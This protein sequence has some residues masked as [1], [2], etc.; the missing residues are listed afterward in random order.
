MGVLILNTWRSDSMPQP[1]TKAQVLKRLQTE[2]SRLEQN[3]ARLTQEE[4]LQPGVV[5]EW[6]V[7]DVLAHLGDWIARMSVWVEAARR[8]ETVYCPDPDF[9]WKQIDRLNQH[10]YEA[11]RDQPLNEVLAYFRATF[12]QFISMVEA[13]PE[14]EMFERGRFAFVGNRP[15]YDWIGLYAAHD[16][17][18]KR[19]IRVWLKTRAVH[20]G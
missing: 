3:L 1:K 10:I 15:L 12:N 4:M 17:W 8:G 14:E 9:T 18:G 11:H 6:S 13:M 16:L 5:G 2:R 7:K 20:T 19:K